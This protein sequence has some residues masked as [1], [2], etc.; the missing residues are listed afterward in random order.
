MLTPAPADY[1][2]YTGTFSVAG[3]SLAVTCS[4][5]AVTRGANITCRAE[6]ASGAAFTLF[7]R[8]TSSLLDGTPFIFD[9]PSI[10]IPA[11]QDYEWTGPAL[12]STRVQ[13][14]IRGTT[15]SRTLRD[16]AVFSVNPRSFSPYLLTNPPAYLRSTR[17]AMTTPPDTITVSPG[18]TTTQY[19]QY[20]NPWIAMTWPDTL[21]T[22]LGI[23]NAGPDS[24]V[25][26]FATELTLPDYDSVFVHPA[27]F[28]TATGAN[29]TWFQDQNGSDP[30]HCSAS[31]RDT[32]ASFTEVHEGKT[33][34]ATSHYAVFNNI[35]SQKRPDLAIESIFAPQGDS[36]GVVVAAQDVFY[37]FSDTLR[38]HKDT[39]D[40][41]SYSLIF[42]GILGGCQFDF[43]PLVF[44]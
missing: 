36:A 23:A 28:S 35:I 20:N 5:A 21:R 11:G 17:G 43:D 15:F 25:V 3:D 31:Q 30:G 44:P 2:A 32:L 34:A 9:Y 41:N 38:F 7:E 39:F 10:A 42:N 18:V 24:G 13:L 16:S 27:L 14:G 40:L 22:R 19:G 12:T 8:R 26:Y 6:L 29:L 4:A 37:M 33:Q 1:V